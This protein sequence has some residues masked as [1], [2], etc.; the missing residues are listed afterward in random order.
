M[1]SGTAGEGPQ[2]TLERVP[3]TVPRR[4]EARDATPG[5]L[6]E[7]A[8]EKVF[9]SYVAS[10]GIHTNAQTK[11]PKQEKQL[12]Y[13]CPIKG[14]GKSVR[15][16]GRRTKDREGYTF[17]IH[18]PPFPKTL[19]TLSLCSSA[20]S[21]VRVGNVV[22]RTYGAFP[23]SRFASIHRLISPNVISGL[24]SPFKTRESG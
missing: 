1:G 18:C 2:R 3:V 24:N 16:N 11:Q 10:A 14:D 8:S 21:K 22:C 15:I 23:S 20:T 6:E 19:P 17:I 9:I 5:G 12:T 4:E 7:Y 13:N